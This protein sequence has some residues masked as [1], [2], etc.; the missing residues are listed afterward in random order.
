MNL[1][2]LI[3]LDD[4]LLPGST[5]K[6][7]PAYISALADYLDVPVPKEKIIQEIYR[8]TYEALAA[9]QIDAHIKERFDQRFYPSLGTSAEVLA[10]KIDTFYAEEFP[11]YS[12][13]DE[14]D[15]Q[16]VQL[17]DTAFEKGYRVAIATN[18]IFPQVAT[19]ERLRWAGV[20]PEKYPFEIVTTY[21]NFHFGKPRPAYY[22]ELIAQIGW[23]EGGFVM[24]GD[25]L[26]WDVEPAK[27]MGIPSF[28][29][30]PAA[31]PADPASMH[32]AGS[33]AEVHSWIDARSEEELNLNLA[34]FDLNLELLKANPAAID[35]LLRQAPEAIWD[36]GPKAEI[37][38]LNEILC[39]L[40]DV[41]REVHT[42]RLNA[43]REEE[44]PF[45]PAIDAD[46]WADERDY[47]RQDGRQAFS[48]FIQ[49][50]KTLLEIS[51]ELPE[52]ANN[53]EI[54]HSI[55][56]PIALDEILRIAARHDSLHVQQI[57]DEIQSK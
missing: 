8:A 11:K 53:K 16:A 52:I 20:A 6:F 34:S 5:E 7:L 14:P 51:A 25:N 41:D 1:T 15:P 39:H 22:L 13:V 54:R 2:L 43:I 27:G 12:P 21:E 35:S 28:R 9:E 30:H 26:E 3:D 38:Q 29:I 32:T 33:L 49:A 17:I 46:S 37:W 36:T 42:P 47:H 48:D 55:F 4:T 10:E 50:R 23:P 44:S 57:F 56:G 40:R 19:Y 24:V 18:P 45:L 31:G